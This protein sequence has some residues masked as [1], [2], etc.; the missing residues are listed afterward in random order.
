M[1]RPQDPAAFAEWRA[2]R[3]EAA[4]KATL[5]KWQEQWRKAPHGR[6]TYR[7]LLELRTWMKYEAS[8]D[9][10]STQILTGH[11]CF[12][13]Y[14]HRM[15]K[16]QTPSCCFGCNEPD[17]AEHHLTLCN[18][19]D[20]E[21]ARFYGKVLMPVQNRPTVEEIFSRLLESAVYWKTFRDF[22]TETLKKKGE[23]ERER[24]LEQHS[25]LL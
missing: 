12:V 13:A 16:P 1:E 21:R 6:W 4:A 15:G 3:K 20:K 2:T 10:Y 8:V 22:C 14:V 18:R 24:Q 17:T 5:E 23:I 9:Y 11:G 7:L 19:W 25:Q